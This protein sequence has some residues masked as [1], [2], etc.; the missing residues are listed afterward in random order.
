[1]DDIRARSVPKCRTNDARQEEPHGIVFSR[2]PVGDHEAPEID[3]ELAVE[4]LCVHSVEFESLCPCFRLR[5]LIDHL[6]VLPANPKHVPS[7]PIG[8]FLGMTHPALVSNRKE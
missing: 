8:R 2:A 4:G 3:A 7:E 1:M 5:K 6:L